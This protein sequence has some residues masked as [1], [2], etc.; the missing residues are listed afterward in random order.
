MSAVVEQQEPMAYAGICPT[1]GHMCA[2]CVDDDDR[3][4]AT[5]KF[6][7]GMVRDGLRVERVTCEQVRQTLKMCS[8]KPNPRKRGAQ[9]AVQRALPL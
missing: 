6:I 8:C 3:K 4:R 1:C 7:A 5:A 2:A 9:P